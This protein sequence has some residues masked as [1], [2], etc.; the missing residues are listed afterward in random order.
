V[1]TL[2]L[3]RRIAVPVAAVAAVAAGFFDWPFHGGGEPPKPSPTVA[4]AGPGPSTPPAPPTATSLSPTPAT[5]APAT[6]APAT[7]GPRRTAPTRRGERPPD[8]A[9]PDPTRP[10]TPPQIAS[11]DDLL[12]H[13]GPPPGVA[14]QVHFFLGGG[15]ECA[16][17]SPGPARIRVEAVV[18]IPSVPTLCLEGFNSGRQASITVTNPTST[19]TLRTR[20]LSLMGVQWAIP[21][22]SPHGCL[23]RRIP[24]HGEEHV[25]VHSDETRQNGVALK[26]DYFG[27]RGY[28][29]PFAGADRFNLAAGDEYGLIFAWRCAGSVDNAH[30]R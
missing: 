22:G 23:H 20:W 9:R 29:R 3:R 17:S 4:D 25:V 13:D 6:S 19:R 30:V 11:L 27:I 18:E 16:E 10:A 24:T 12:E 21:T 2:R 7:A 15:G 5:S 28:R 8:R 1:I 14:D 26:V